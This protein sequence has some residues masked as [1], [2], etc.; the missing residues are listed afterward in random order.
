MQG[1][2]A[3]PEEEAV[4]VADGQIGGGQILAFGDMLRHEGEDVLFVE[5][6]CIERRAEG[7]GEMVAG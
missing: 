5:E 3:A 7:A 4:I 1:D 2:G 6:P